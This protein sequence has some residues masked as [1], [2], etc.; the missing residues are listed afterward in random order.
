MPLEIP[1]PSGVRS[2]A[3]PNS[4]YRKREKP[5]RSPAREPNR[6]LRTQPRRCKPSFALA[7]RKTLLDSLLNQPDQASY[8]VCRWQWTSFSFDREL[9]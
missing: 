2:D 6:P 5:V 9:R 7:R 3:R 4:G 8:F 1:A